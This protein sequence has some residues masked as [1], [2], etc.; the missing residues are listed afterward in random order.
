MAKRK[1]KYKVGDVFEAPSLSGATYIGQVVDD[2]KSEIGAIFCYFYGESGDLSSNNIISASLVTPDLIERGVW[3]I[4]GNEAVPKAAAIR[5]LHEAKGNGFVGSVVIGSGLVTEYIDTF[6]GVM[7]EQ[8]WPDL[9]YVK[10]FFLSY[11]DRGK[12]F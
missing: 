6:Y 12:R 10:R 11:P 7:D 9:M 3:R 5:K 2:T 8:S 1:I 4:I